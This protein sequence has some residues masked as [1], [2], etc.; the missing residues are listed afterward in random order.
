MLSSG[1][2]PPPLPP[3]HF[4]KSFFLSLSLLQRPST[5]IRSLV[6][7]PQAG[8]VVAQKK[9]LVLALARNIDSQPQQHWLSLRPELKNLKKLHAENKFRFGMSPKTSFPP[10]K[11][12]SVL[13]DLGRYGFVQKRLVFPKTMS[14]KLAL[15]AA[16]A[17]LSQELSFADFETLKESNDLF[18]GVSYND[19][20]QD[21]YINGGQKGFPLRCQAL[22]DC[23][24]VEGFGRFLP[25]DGGELD[26]ECSS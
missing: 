6:F 2:R 7:L 11:V 18:P 15:R 21:D 1:L 8:A 20:R 22:G 19:F 26:I 13:F 25:K 9:Q 16:E 12:R 4:V 24:F 14:A 23:T 17:F 5:L 3:L 10:A